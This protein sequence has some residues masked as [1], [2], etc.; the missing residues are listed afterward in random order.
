MTEAKTKTAE[1][2]QQKPATAQ[3]PGNMDVSIEEV[4]R[5]L[6]EMQLII[7]MQEREILRLQ[8]ALTLKD[9]TH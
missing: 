1:A 9:K 5:W 6:G 3:Q 4:Q 8:N 7:K 2:Q